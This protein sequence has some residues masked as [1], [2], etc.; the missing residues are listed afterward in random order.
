MAGPEFEQLYQAL[1]K[2]TPIPQAEDEKL[3]ALF[4]KVVLAQGDYFVKAGEDPQQIGFVV[5][6][7]LR[8]HYIDEA[9]NDFTKSFCCEGEFA[10]VYGALLL[11]VPSHIFIQALEPSV[12]LV[13]QFK[14]FQALMESHVCWQIVARKLVEF[15]FLRKEE[16]ESELLLYDAETRYRRFLQKYPGLETRVKQYHVASY[17]G[18]TPVSLSRIRAGLR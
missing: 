5:S 16:R 1:N 2:L 9:G 15:L 7:L 12:M 13:I 10:G 4:H 3:P 6:G 18:I 14:D 17:L 11:N 8:L